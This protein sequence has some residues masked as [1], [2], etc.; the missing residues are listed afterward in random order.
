MLIYISFK[1]TRGFIKQSKNIIFHKIIINP[2]IPGGNK[3][4]T[5]T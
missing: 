3:K 1:I 5:Y 2:L 4:V